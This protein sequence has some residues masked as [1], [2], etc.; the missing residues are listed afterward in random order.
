[1]T[2]EE[3][4][5]LPKQCRYSFVIEFGEFLSSRKLDGEG[6]AKLFWLEAFYAEMYFEAGKDLPSELRA[7][8]ATKGLIP[9][10]REIDI[11]D[12]YK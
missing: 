8:E 11:K 4:L 12:V 7:F 10:L 1:M 9:Y 5:S 3:F 6:V 2:L